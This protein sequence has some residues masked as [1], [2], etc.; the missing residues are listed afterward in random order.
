LLDRTT[1][2]ERAVQEAFP[3]LDKAR[4]RTL[5]G[6]GLWAS[7]RVGEQ[8]DLGARRVERNRRPRLGG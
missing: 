6:S 1:H 4:T 7:D 8:A 2:L 3:R 5:T